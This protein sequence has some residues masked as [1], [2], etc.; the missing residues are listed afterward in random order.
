MADEVSDRRSSSPGAGQFTISSRCPTLSY[1][2]A[3]AAIDFLERA[4]GFRRCFM[5][6]DAQGGIRHS[7]VTLGNGVIMVSS[8]K[9]AEGRVGPSSGGAQSG[10]LCVFVPDPDAHHARAKAAGATITRDLQT[11]EYGARG[12]M[13][14]V[15]A[16][17]SWQFGDY[18]PG[19]YWDRDRAIPHSGVAGREPFSQEAR[20]AELRSLAGRAD[21]C[22]VVVRAAC[23]RGAPTHNL[24][25][26]STR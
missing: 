4:I 15:P 11:E 18:L 16:G 8:S 24:S 6:P 17:H 14:R 26:E 2:D 7:E 10:G 5:V 20:K 9:P 13:A 1:D 22:E 25:Q 12:Y 3:Y 19:A 23:R 21:M